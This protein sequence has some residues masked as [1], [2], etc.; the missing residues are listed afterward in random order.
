[1]VGDESLAGHVQKKTW[2]DDAG[3]L[4]KSLAWG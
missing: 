3:T 4:G 2:P 1:M